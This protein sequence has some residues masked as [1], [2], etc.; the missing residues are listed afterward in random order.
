ML[1]ASSVYFKAMFAGN[2]AEKT[3]GTI[4]IHEV[5]PEAMKAVINYAYT[6]EIKV[7]ICDI[8]KGNESLVEKCQFQ[9]FFTPFLISSKCL[10]SYRV[11][12]N[13]SM[14]NQFKIKVFEHCF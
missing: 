14:L 1:A 9:F 2:L 7:G 4:V 6:S 8:I 13:L 11:M 12:K 3:L 10:Q 5:D